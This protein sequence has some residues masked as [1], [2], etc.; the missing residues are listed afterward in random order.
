MRVAALIALAWHALSPL[1]WRQVQGN[2]D[3]RQ[4]VTGAATALAV[5]SP[6]TPQTGIN[7]RS[8]P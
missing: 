6:A 8:T 7:H 5:I 1:P 2:S 4:S 3:T